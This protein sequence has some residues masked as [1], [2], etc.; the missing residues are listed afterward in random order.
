MRA[1]RALSVQPCQHRLDDAATDGQ[2]LVRDLVAR[3]ALATRV[4][5]ADLQTG[6]QRRPF[7]DQARGPSRQTVHRSRRRRHDPVAD[8]PR[9]G[10]RSR[11]PTQRCRRSEHAGRVPHPVRRPRPVSR[12]PLQPTPTRGHARDVARAGSRPLRR[13]SWPATKPGP[14][15]ITSGASSIDGVDVALGQPRIDHDVGA[16][17]RQL[18]RDEHGDDTG[19]CEL[20]RLVGV[21]GEHRPHALDVDLAV[22][23]R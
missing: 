21:S 13:Q 5:I 17:R 19:R 18:G 10:H 12:C 9:R 3:R 15:P 14:S 22:E 1:R 23:D 8:H 20:D 7:R 11:R 16:E 4:D 6:G 2:R